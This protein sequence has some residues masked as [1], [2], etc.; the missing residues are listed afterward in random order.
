M[1]NVPQR[2]DEPDVA[3]DH[4]LTWHEFDGERS[5]EATIA[6]AVARATE[7]SPT[8]LAPVADAVDPDALDRLLRSLPETGDAGIS[9]RYDEFR[10]TARPSGE[11]WIA[12]PEGN[13]GLFDWDETRA[14]E[15]VCTVVADAED[16]APTE[17]APLNDVIDPDA[18]ESLC[19]NGDTDHVTFPYLG[20]V[21]TVDRSGLVIAE[22]ESPEEPDGE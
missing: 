16:V 7:T 21:V 18:L 2:W 13:V 4:Y 10:V 12:L 9:F 17:L 20:Y 3:A 6:K 15:A 8:E 1:V 5:V 14:T 11:I 19:R 22:P